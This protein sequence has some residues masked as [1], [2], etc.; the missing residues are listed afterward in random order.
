MKSTRRS[1]SSMHLRDSPM[2]HGQRKRHSR[3]GY[4]WRYISFAEE[5]PPVLC[6]PGELNQSHPQCGTGTLEIDVR[7]RDDWAVVTVTDSGKDIP[8]EVK[9]RIFEP[10]FTTKPAGEGSGPGPD[11]VKRLL[12]N[13]VGESKRRVNREGRL[14]DLNKPLE[15]KVEERTQEFVESAKM[16]ALDQIIAGVAHAVASR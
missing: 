14:D 10:F 8:D 11:I 15:Q 16:V 2:N 4:S 3:Y 1:A 6:Y 12:R 5:L 13:T 7:Q 9:E